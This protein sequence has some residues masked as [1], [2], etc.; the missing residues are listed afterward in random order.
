[1]QCLNCEF[2]FVPSQYHLSEP[3]E[4]KRYDTHNN[5]PEDL[6]YRQSLSRL[7]EPLN[8]LISSDSYGLDFGC[9][10]GPTL[11]LMLEKEGHQVDLYDKYYVKDL[12]VFNKEFDFVT[13][14]EVIEHLSDPLFE[15]ER[16]TSILKP[17]GIIAIMTQTLSRDIDF[18]A[19]YY[20]NDPSHIGFYNQK[21][22]Q[23]LA[24][25]LEL[26]MSHYSDR[27]IFFKK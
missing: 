24:D 16:L 21:S 19:W 13:L 17:G 4:R 12:S 7:T 10:P 3:E 22:L 15:L 5:N 9:G 14:T 18:E 27:V 2:V 26:Q 25:Q 23:I 8:E 20:K 6:R 1:M 11:S